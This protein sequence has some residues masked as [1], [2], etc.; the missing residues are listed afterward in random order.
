MQ[1]RAQDPSRHGKAAIHPAQ[2]SAPSP[3]GPKSVASAS[4]TRYTRVDP[5]T[6]RQLALSQRS[7]ERADVWECGLRGLRDTVT[8][9]QFVVEDEAL[10]GDLDVA[11]TRPAARPSQTSMHTSVAS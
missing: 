8:G 2:Q 5:P 6:F 7:L 1:E 4:N 9:E 3:D 10:A 11:D